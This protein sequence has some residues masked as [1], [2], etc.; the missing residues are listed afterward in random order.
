MATTP[1]NSESSG[2]QVANQLNSVARDVQAMQTTQ[3]FKDEAG[4]R[5]VILDKDGL[6]TSPAGIDVFTAGNDELTF[7]SNQNTFKIVL[8]GTTTI[9][10]PAP[11]NTANFTITH[12][13]GYVPITVAYMD[14][15]N[16]FIPL[17]VTFWETV[18]SR[19]SATIEFHIQTVTSTDITFQCTNWGYFTGTVFPIKYYFLQETAN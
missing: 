5:R 2:A 4:T 1:T 16:Q 6:R 8:S 17:P 3:V 10:T 18:A 15:S 11:I 19:G 9:T 12:D 7:N 14:N 13:L